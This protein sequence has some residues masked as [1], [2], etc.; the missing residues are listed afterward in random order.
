MTQ[1]EIYNDRSVELTPS[2]TRNSEAWLGMMEA[3]KWIKSEIDDA[4]AKENE[5]DK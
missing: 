5:N 3:L 1:Q 2:A 4:L